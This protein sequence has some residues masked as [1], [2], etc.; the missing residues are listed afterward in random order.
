MLCQYFRLIGVLGMK[1]AETDISGEVKNGVKFD[2]E[3]EQFIWLHMTSMKL[4]RD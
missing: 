4:K 2:L 1:I 3:S